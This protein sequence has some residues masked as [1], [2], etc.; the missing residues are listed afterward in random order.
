MSLMM[1][2][3]VVMREKF[4]KEVSEKVQL[5][6]LKMLK[7]SAVGFVTFSTVKGSRGRASAMA[8]LII[9]KKE[10]SNLRENLEEID[11]LEVS[12]TKLHN[13]IYSL[14]MSLLNVDAQLA[15]LNFLT[16]K[17][18]MRSQRLLTLKHF[19]QHELRALEMVL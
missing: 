13:R 12:E 3:Q 7:V 17:D 11:S 15:E 19:Y 16:R 9:I 4:S 10:V 8:N 14:K 1:I 18:I 6:T 2:I 5:S